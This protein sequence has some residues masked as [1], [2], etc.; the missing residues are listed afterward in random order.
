MFF[1]TKN[2]E[3]SPV[4]VCW[5]KFLW[6]YLFQVLEYHNGK[7]AEIGKLQKRRYDHAVL[8]IGPQQ[9]P[10]LTGDHGLRFI[11]RNL[12]ISFYLV[13]ESI[14]NEGGYWVWM[15]FEEGS[16]RSTPLSKQKQSKNAI[17]VIKQ[18]LY[19]FEAFSCWNALVNLRQGPLVQLL[20]L[21]KPCLLSPRIQ[22]SKLPSRASLNVRIRVK[23]DDPTGGGKIWGNR[24]FPQ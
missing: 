11:T 10:C 13:G 14:E 16:W 24:F 6:L 8:S 4:H 2:K 21:N 5:V 12:K 18:I 20:F 19:L 7:W 23:D 17:E 15:V 3:M 22:L 9:L 1:E